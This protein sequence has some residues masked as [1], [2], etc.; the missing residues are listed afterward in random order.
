MQKLIILAFICF[1]LIPCISQEDWEL[2]SDK[3]DVQVYYRDHEESPIKEL[4]IVFKLDASL[5]EI[6]DFLNDVPKYK[7]WIYRT[8]E[9][10][11]I[12][13]V[14]EDDFIYYTAT[15]FPWPFSDRDM[16]IRSKGEFITD[17]IYRSVSTISESDAYPPK[18]DMVRITDMDI[19]WQ[20]EEISE[21][22][23]LI[24]YQMR[25]DPGGAIPAW[26]VNLALEAGPSNTI[27]NM[28]KE[29]SSN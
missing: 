5:K 11:L 19:T 13:T 9:A 15:D 23:T 12:E 1:P 4:K 8:K 24:I 7:N 28:R 29:L 14:S 10:Q 18:K 2:S 21:S 27:K 16:V 3:K 25:S 26:V 17:K 20:M 6:I 22:K